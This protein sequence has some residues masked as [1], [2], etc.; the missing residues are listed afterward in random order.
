MGKVDACKLHR[1][2]KVPLT[3]T[4]KTIHAGPRKVPTCSI[5]KQIGHRSNG[6]RMPPD[7]KRRVLDLEEFDYDLLMLAD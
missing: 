2:G 7:S 3:K 5:C 4:A 1:A 6:C